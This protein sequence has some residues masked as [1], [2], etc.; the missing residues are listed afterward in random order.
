MYTGV[1]RVRNDMK[2]RA[3]QLAVFGT[4]GDLPLRC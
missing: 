3:I 4:L 2:T 1:Q